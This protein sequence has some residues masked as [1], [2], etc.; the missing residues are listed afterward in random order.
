M[1]IERIKK[2]IQDNGYGYDIE[3]TAE[4]IRGWNDDYS[5]AMHIELKTKIAWLVEPDES[6]SR[7]I[8][9]KP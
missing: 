7:L 4:Y 1:S 8:T 9:L 2:V 6:F 3:V 5:E